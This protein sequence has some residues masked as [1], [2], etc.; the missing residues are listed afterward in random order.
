MSEGFISHGC[1]RLVEQDVPGFWESASLQQ[2]RRPVERGTLLVRLNW[3]IESIT[4][5]DLAHVRYHM[6]S[7]Q[8]IF[9]MKQENRFLTRAGERDTLR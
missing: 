9:I 1:L 8:I 3:Q 7:S 6:A 2:S 5:P 4:P